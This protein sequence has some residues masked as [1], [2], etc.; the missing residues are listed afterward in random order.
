[1][2]KLIRLSTDNTTFTSLPSNA[3]DLSSDGEVVDDSILGNTFESGFTSI[4]N[5]TL[6]ADGIYKGVPGYQTCILKQGTS[7]FATTEDL[8][9]VS[10]QEYRVNDLTKI[11][12]MLITQ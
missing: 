5:W 8:S 2:S 4:L 11:S 10:G 6:S 12:G 7:T 9:L 1:M 3:G